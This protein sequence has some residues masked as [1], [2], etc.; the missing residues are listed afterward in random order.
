M[1]F[2]TINL[3]LAVLSFFLS[4]VNLL[5]ISSLQSALN[6]FLENQKQLNNSAHENIDLDHRAILLAR[7]NEI[8]NKKFSTKF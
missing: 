4:F 3:V 5:K 6:E 1:N 7:L 2:Q 8:Q